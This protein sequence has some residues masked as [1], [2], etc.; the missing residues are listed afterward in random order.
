[1]S[2]TDLWAYRDSKW[3]AGALTAGMRASLS[4]YLWRA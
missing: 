1:M 2:A 3:R 4:A